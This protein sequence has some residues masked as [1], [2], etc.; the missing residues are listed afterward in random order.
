M[1]SHGAPAYPD[2]NSS[3]QLPKI[4]AASQVGVSG[5]RLTAAQGACQALWPYQAP[6]QAQQRQQLAGDLTFAQCMRSHGVPNWPDPTTVP[7]NG[8][9]EFVISVSRDGFNPHSPRIISKGVQCEHVLPAG[10]R[11][12]VSTSP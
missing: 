2:P 9:V 12:H 4:T 11:P 5:S 8:L 10:V 1:R 3:G 6:T 7:P